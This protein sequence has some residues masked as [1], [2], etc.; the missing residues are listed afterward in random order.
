MDVFTFCDLQ[1]IDDPRTSCFG[2]LRHL[3]ANGALSADRASKLGLVPC[4]DAAPLV[5]HEVPDPLCNYLS[6][7]NQ[8]KHREYRNRI[9]PISKIH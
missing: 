5:L 2:Q 3:V 7:I 4:F 9:R 6:P 8:T 1:Q